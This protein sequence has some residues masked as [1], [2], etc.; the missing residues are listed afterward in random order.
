MTR[1][2]LYA[3]FSTDLQ[4]ASSIEDQVRVCQRLIEGQGWT[5]AQIYSDLGMSGAT[6]LRPGYQKLLEDARA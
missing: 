5:V 3:R 2:A 1:A 4:S 6:H